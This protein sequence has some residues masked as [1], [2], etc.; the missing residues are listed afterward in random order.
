MWWLALFPLAGVLIG[1]ALYFLPLWFGKDD[2]PDEDD[3]EK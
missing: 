3:S 2:S 1:V